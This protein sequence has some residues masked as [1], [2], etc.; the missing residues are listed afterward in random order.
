[1]YPINANIAHR[2][3][4]FYH[5][6]LVDGDL[7]AAAIP[8]VAELPA[9]ERAFLAAFGALVS[10]GEGSCEDEAALW[11]ELCRSFAGALSSSASAEL[12]RE[13]RR[14]VETFKE[15]LP[16]QGKVYQSTLPYCTR[17]PTFPSPVTSVQFSSATRSSPSLCEELAIAE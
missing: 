10:N 12:A 11:R 15:F 4:N 7:V 5:F 9:D 16:P 8:L 1:M 13:T 2:K 3:I 14:C 17:T 6:F